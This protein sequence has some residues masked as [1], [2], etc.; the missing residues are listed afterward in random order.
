MADFHQT[1][2][3]N[4]IEALREAVKGSHLQ[5]TQLKPEDLRGDIVQAGA[6]ALVERVAPFL[7]GPGREKSG[8]D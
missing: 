5:P 4:G 7:P 6:F 3:I 8:A 2:L 1:L